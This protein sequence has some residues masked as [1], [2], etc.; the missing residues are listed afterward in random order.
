MAHLKDLCLH[1]NGFHDAIRGER[2]ATIRFLRK[3]TGGSKNCNPIKTNRINK[4]NLLSGV[5]NAKQ[6]LSMKN[7]LI[8]ALSLFI[9]AGCQSSKP[10]K[11][12][13]SNVIT[14]TIMPQKTFVEKIAGTDF[15]VNVLIP[16]G[17][18]PEDGNLLPSQMKDVAGSA[19]WFKMGYL[20]FEIAWDE[21]IRQ[22]NTE[23]KV[24]NLSEGL[25]LIIEEEEH[26][27]HVHLGGIDPHT[28]LSPSLVKQMAKRI[29]DEVTL[30]NP[31]KSND[32]KYN[33]LEF[34][35][36]IDLLDIEIR[37][38]LSQFKGRKFVIF[39]P[40]LSYFAREYGLQQYALEMSGKEPTPQQMMNVVDI[41]KNENIKVIYIQSEF[42]MD[43]ARVFAEEI[44]GRV[45]QIRPLDAA[46]TDNLKEMSSVFADNF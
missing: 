9:M 14:V 31:E 4:L 16:P 28:W 29:L 7:I 11:T 1:Q 24:V 22:A 36:E 46:W 13:S 43:N 2:M 8:L 10:K 41:A 42:D 32:Y 26:G 30:L 39:H 21:K 19:I 15:K 34:V 18:N 17:S 12:D 5:F 38:K 25:D 27:D 40:S 23:M 33:Y 37:N 45:I 44:K 35:K 3:K 20:G 6:N